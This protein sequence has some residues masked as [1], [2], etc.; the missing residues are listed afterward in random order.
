M[1]LSLP[2]ESTGSMRSRAAGSL[3]SRAAKW[4]RRRSRPGFRLSRRVAARPNAGGARAAQRSGVGGTVAA[5]PPGRR[6]AAVAAGPSGRRGDTKPPAGRRAKS[7]CRCAA[8]PTEGRVRGNFAARP[9]RQVAPQP[10]RRVALPEP[11]SAAGSLPLI[12]GS[13]GRCGGSRATGS[14]RSRRAV[15]GGSLR[16][17]GQGR[18]GA[19]GEPS[20]LGTGP[21]ESIMIRD[22]PSGTIIMASG[23]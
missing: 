1:S 7:Q 2:P 10:D 15:A 11:R 19:A 3:R 12:G 5:G 17:P 13:P 23:G 8:S 4:Q 21:A 18:C 22:S 20:V 14:I 9:G 16:S 6:V